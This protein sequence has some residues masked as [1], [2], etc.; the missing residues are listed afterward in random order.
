MLPSLSQAIKNFLTMLIEVLHLHG[1]V[2]IANANMLKL[3]N[4]LM[5]WEHHT[6]KYNIISA[7]SVSTKISIYENLYA[8]ILMQ[9]GLPCA[10]TFLM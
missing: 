2:I 9:S 7:N 8:H 10:T 4:E 3:D 6:M 5:T 1:H